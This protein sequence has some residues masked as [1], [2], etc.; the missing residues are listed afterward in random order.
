ML[1]EFIRTDEVAFHEL[2]TGS[3]GGNKQFGNAA[4]GITVSE[5]NRERKEAENVWPK[6]K[7]KEPG[8]NDVPEAKE[9]RREDSTRC[10]WFIIT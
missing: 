9:E 5:K 10:V 6:R 7:G 4:R 2:Y 1:V 3:Q 8:E